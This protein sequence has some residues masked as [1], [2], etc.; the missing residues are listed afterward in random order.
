MGEDTLEE[1]KAPLFLNQKICAFV[2]ILHP[3][4]RCPG[5]LAYGC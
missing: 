4:Y 3:I 5:A 2:P 1:K